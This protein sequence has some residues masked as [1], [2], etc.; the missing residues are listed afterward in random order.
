MKVAKKLSSKMATFPP[1]LLY[2]ICFHHP[3]ACNISIRAGSNSSIAAVTAY[4][5]VHLVSSLDARQEAVPDPG[6][7]IPSE[8]I[9]SK[10]PGGSP[11]AKINRSRWRSCAASVV[12][13]AAC[14]E[15]PLNSADRL[16]PYYVFDSITLIWQ[17]FL[18]IFGKQ[19]SRF[20]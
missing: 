15:S 13:P 9:T 18:A 6:T 17:N 14:D 19:V 2:R 7:E 20:R 4:V 10:S 3:S 1:G 5:G 8:T 11:W 16:L 12:G